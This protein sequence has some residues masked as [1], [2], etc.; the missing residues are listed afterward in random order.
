LCSGEDIKHIS[1]TR[2][3]LI[4]E[5]MSFNIRQAACCSV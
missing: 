2:M 4:R 1:R 5:E 3:L